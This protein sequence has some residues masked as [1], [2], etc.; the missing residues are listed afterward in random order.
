MIVRPLFT[1][2]MLLIAIQLNMTH[3]WLNVRCLCDLDAPKLALFM[4]CFYCFANP[5]EVQTSSKGIATC[6][7]S[8]S[9]TGS[10]SLLRISCLILL[11]MLIYVFNVENRNDC[12][13]I[14]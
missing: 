1:V 8:L 6:L 7:W 2:D 4:W 9:L 14:I 12:S 10:Y 13:K 5:S 3:L 11:M